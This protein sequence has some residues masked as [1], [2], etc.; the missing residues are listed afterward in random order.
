ME[1][2]ETPFA[3][4]QDCLRFSWATEELTIALRKVEAVAWNAVEGSTAA[5]FG[6]L[7][8]STSFGSLMRLRNSWPVVG[9][10]DV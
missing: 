7:G 2:V 3:S 6:R 9:G 1:K 4:G 8:Q 5:D 10:R